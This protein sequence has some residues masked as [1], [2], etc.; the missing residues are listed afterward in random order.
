MVYAVLAVA[1]LGFV[2]PEGMYAAILT[3]VP[4]QMHQRDWKNSGEKMNSSGIEQI[5]I[6]TS[7]KPH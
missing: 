5:S 2:Q 3:P 7:F 6:G 1:V 4:K